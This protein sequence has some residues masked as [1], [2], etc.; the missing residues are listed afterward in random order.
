M[1]LGAPRTMQMCNP[2]AYFLACFW[3]KSRA[4]VHFF[5][6]AAL[7]QVGL[8]INAKASLTRIIIFFNL[9]ILTHA[10]STNKGNQVISD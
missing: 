7:Q 4:K 1:Q 8:Q 5:L 3:P 6:A 2:L 10:S 9:T